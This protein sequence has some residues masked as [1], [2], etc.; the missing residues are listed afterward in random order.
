[1]KFQSLM[2]L[3]LLLLAFDSG[4]VLLHPEAFPAL[5]N[6]A[7]AVSAGALVDRSGDLVPNIQHPTGAK[8]RAQD[9][10][11]PVADAVPAG[12]PLPEPLPLSLLGLGLALL[13]W[14]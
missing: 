5:P 9:Q 3:A 14:T 8:V 4:A 11:A 7:A 13:G 1:M 12:Q 2:A 10:A 6:A